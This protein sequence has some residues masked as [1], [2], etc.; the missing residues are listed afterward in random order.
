MV[1]NKRKKYWLKILAT[2]FLSFFI[3][4]IFSNFKD[5]ENTLLNADYGDIAIA[6]SATLASCLIGSYAF[7][8]INQIFGLRD[9]NNRLFTIGFITIA[10]NNL[11]TLG[12]S[13]GHT[14][15]ILL[16]KDKHQIKNILTASFF[17]SYLNILALAILSF[18]SIGTAFFSI[19]IPQ[20]IFQT[21]EIIF[22]VYLIVIFFISFVTFKHNFRKKI[23]LKMAEI[24]KKILK[25]DFISDFIHIDQILLSGLN[26]LGKFGLFSWKILGLILLDWIFSAIALFFCF[27][28]LKIF[29][30]PTLLFSGYFVG[31]ATGL[32]SMLPGGLGAQ[33]FS[34]IA[35]YNIFGISI[36]MATSIDILFRITYYFIPFLV[37]LI[38]YWHLVYKIKK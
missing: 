1:K 5:I 28:A 9:D 37:A 32:I 16:L 34:Q 4:I 25:K 24:I 36:S 21:F 11:I 38:M 33:D 20:K 12:G 27:R 29:L 14:L 26:T 2:L 13:T 8:E 17:F 7:S 15:R 23:L 35:F 30:A 3:F 19:D 18:I 31:I 6:I 10:F 22:F